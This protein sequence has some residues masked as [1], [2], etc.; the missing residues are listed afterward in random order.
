MEGIPRPLSVLENMFV[1]EV[2]TELEWQG[3]EISLSPPNF[4]QSDNDYNWL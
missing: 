3:S 4:G 1:L 2:S